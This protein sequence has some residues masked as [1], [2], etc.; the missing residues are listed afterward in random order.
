[1]RVTSRTSVVPYKRARKPLPEIARELNVDAVVEGSVG[2]SG[3]RVRVRAQLIRAATDQHLWADN[4]ERELQDVLALQSEV[5]SAIARQVQLKLTAQQL[6]Q[7]GSL[8]PVKPAAYEAYLKGRYAWNKRSVTG[9]QDGIENF[10]QAIGIDPSYAAAYSGLADS[11]TT[12]GYLR[13]LSP[14]ESFPRANAAATK[15]LELDP[16]L[17]E[18]H[19]SLAYANLYYE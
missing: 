14:E 3:N 10:R 1:M 2:R 4:F 19:A 8:G 11:Y 15:A 16:T 7:W 17:A 12:L 13:Y 6:G 5:A 18:P 9:L